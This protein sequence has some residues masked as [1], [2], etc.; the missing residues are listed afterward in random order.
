MEAVEPVG[1]PRCKSRGGRATWS[2]WLLPLRAVASVT[3]R[4]GSY[5]CRSASSRPWLAWF[6]LKPSPSGVLTVSSAPDSEWRTPLGCSS[7]S[8]SCFRLVSF[9]PSGWLE[10]RFGSLS[11]VFT[12]FLYLG[13]FV[14]PRSM[15]GVLEWAFPIGLFLFSAMGLPCLRSS[16]SGH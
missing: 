2:P 3:F 13:V 9:Y 14:T 6:S 11:P 7:C 10:R 16:G 8:V 12:P 5:H 4:A 1:S 15:G